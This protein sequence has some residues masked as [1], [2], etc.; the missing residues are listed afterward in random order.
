MTESIRRIDEAG[1]ATV[2]RGMALRAQP[3]R[4]MGRPRA[5]AP[6]ITDEP[7]APITAAEA[8]TVVP[9]EAILTEA[10][11]LA[12]QHGHREGWEQGRQEGYEAGLREGTAA[13][14]QDVLAQASELITEAARKSA[15]EAAQRSGL[16]LEQ[17]ALQRWSQHKAR[18]D[19]LLTTLP[20]QIAQRME[21]VQ[22]DLLALCMET[23]V[24][25]LGKEAVQPPIIRS[26]VRQALDQLQSR[27]LVRVE[28]HPDDLAALRT[29]P[30][31]NA[32]CEQQAPGAQ[33]VGNEQITSGGCVVVSPEGSLDARLDGQLQ[34]FRAMLM[35]SRNAL[36]ASR[37]E[38]RT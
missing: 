35:D 7:Q 34:T 12:R 3:V 5:Q 26:A 13:A 29:L 27:P 36:A 6:T 23:L 20:A 38:A 28:L 10:R 19:A 18:L 8:R 14:K 30:G 22:D 11:E 16:A 1:A 33:W 17:E 9:D 32:W 37:Q 31:W 24:H 15:E 21:A 4:L 25:I 2:L